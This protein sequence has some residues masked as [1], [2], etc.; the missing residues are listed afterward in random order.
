VRAWRT[1]RWLTPQGLCGVQSTSHAP[2]SMFVIGD[3]TAQEHC[4]P[5]SVCIA[6]V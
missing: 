5:L 3:T 4:A 2:T 6:L 1:R